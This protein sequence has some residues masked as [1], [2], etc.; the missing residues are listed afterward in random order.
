MSAFDPK[1]HLRGMTERMHR[2]LVNDLNALPPDRSNA[3]PGGCARG[4]LN[5]VAECAMVNRFVADYLTSGEAKRLPPEQRNAHLASFDTPEK[6]L[7]YLDAETR[8]LL[9]VIDGLDEATLGDVSDQPLGRPMSRFAVA[10]LPAVHM[11]YHDGQLNYL[12]TL[13]GDDQ[14]HWA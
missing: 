6:A 14:N 1:A 5:L 11:M 8:H 13:Y 7:A 12:Q 10:E 4:A 9:A 3:S 2:L